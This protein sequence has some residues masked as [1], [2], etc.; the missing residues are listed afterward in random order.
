M[1]RPE[2]SGGEEVESMPTTAWRFGG[3]EGADEAVLKLKQVEAAKL[4]DR[5]SVV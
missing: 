3:T 5:K 1:S 2:L 4:V